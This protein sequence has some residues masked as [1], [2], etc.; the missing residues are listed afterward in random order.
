MSVGDK[1]KNVTSSLSSYVVCCYVDILGD[2]VKHLDLETNPDRETLIRNWKRD[3]SE[4]LKYKIEGKGFDGKTW[5][6]SD[7]FIYLSHLPFRD[8]KRF[9]KEMF[10]STIVHCSV[11][12]LKMMLSNIFL[13]GGISQGVAYV[14][15]DHLIGK[16]LVDAYIVESKIANYPVIALSKRSEMFI[17]Y[18]KLN[19]EFGRQCHY[20]LALAP[21]ASGNGDKKGEGQMVLVNPFSNLVISDYVD[22]FGAA[23]EDAL[24]N[25]I[26]AK[27]AG[28][29]HR[30][31]YDEKI[32]PK[33]AFLRDLWNYSQ[34]IKWKIP[35]SPSDSVTIISPIDSLMK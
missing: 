10:R 11:L 3:R 14:D 25:R 29:L 2:R 28:R 9:Y 15:D 33:Y 13:R 27:I 23:S 21:L 5:S 31:Q 35:V 22:N 32:Y 16:P 7:S 18:R 20:R 8:R 4:M 6:F 26:V 12:T 1:P 30:F 34:D 24:R 19:S 17:C